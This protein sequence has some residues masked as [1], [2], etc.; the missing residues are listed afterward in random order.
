MSNTEAEAVKAIEAANAAYLDPNA[1]HA[2]VRSAEQASKAAV[3]RHAAEL[4]VDPIVAALQLR[5]ITG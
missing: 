2:A 1:T 5:Q 3:A 4:G